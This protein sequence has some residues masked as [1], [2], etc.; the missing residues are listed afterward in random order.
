MGPR[1]R[2]LLLVVDDDPGLQS[3]MSLRLAELDFEVLG[4]LHYEAAVAHL[5]LRKP[6]LVCIDVGLPTRSGYE[7]CELIRGP[8]GLSAVPVLMTCESALPEDMANAEVAG[9]DAFLKKPFAMDEL[10]AHIEA[11]V[12]PARSS[13]PQARRLLAWP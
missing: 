3:A 12:N 10:V 9:A 11:L 7:L 1:T 6:H 8:L 2:R 4:A 13:V 5:A